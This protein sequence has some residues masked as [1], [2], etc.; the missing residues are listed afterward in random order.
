MA[1]VDYDAKFQLDPVR[2]AQKYA[3]ALPDGPQNYGTTLS[4]SQYNSQFGGTAGNLVR[5][6]KYGRR[7]SGLFWGD[8][9]QTHAAGGIERVHMTTITH[10]HRL[11]G[12][13]VPVYSVTAAS[14]AEGATVLQFAVAPNGFDAYFLPWNGLGGVVY[15]TLP[16]TGP[17][18]F[19]TAALSGCSIMVLGPETSPTVYHCG[20][21][22]W[23]NSPY[24]QAPFA[25]ANMQDD[26]RNPATPRTYQLWVDVVAYI[27]N[28]PQATFEQR[29]TIDSR[30]YV[31]DFDPANPRTTADS[32]VLEREL[33]QRK[34]NQ[35]ASAT[36]YGCV[37]G[38][39]DNT[40]KWAFYLQ[41]NASM[42][43][44]TIRACRPISVTKFFPYWQGIPRR[45]T[46]Q[47]LP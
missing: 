8:W 16:A 10:Q 17:R 1:Y 25:Q 42:L 31:S 43:Y 19:F 28:D 14:Q 21:D 41:A 36:P 29:S 6:P 44:G 2:A 22:D 24:V 45:W 5:G 11:G 47:M 35:N 13:N 34:P 7:L 15:M 46:W 38:V 39:R 37:F 33:Q 27:A 3:L 32:R 26:P 23:N 4:T 30:H 20:V 12:A 40:G 18:Y 9:G